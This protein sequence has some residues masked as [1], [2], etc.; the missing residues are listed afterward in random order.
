MSS[1]NSVV[2]NEERRTIPVR[3][4]WRKHYSDK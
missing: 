2:L 4:P 3:E 1:N